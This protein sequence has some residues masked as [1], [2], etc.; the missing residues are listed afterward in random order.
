M[1]SAID[2][3]RLRV[4]RLYPLRREQSS[5]RKGC[6]DEFRIAGPITEN[7]QWAIE[8]M[9]ATES[10]LRDGDWIGDHRIPLDEEAWDRLD[11]Q[12]NIWRL[13]GLIASP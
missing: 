11:G 13:N 6:A 2:Q 12:I 4:Y 1:D 7:V 9:L 10:R 8:K 5:E 3:Q